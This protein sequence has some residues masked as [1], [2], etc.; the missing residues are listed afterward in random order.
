MKATGLCMVALKIS[1]TCGYSY[2]FEGTRYCTREVCIQ[3]EDN[4]GNM[5]LEA[6]NNEQ[7]TTIR[8]LRAEVERLNKRAENLEQTALKIAKQRDTA[9]AHAAT[10]VGALAPFADAFTEHNEGVPRCF[11]CGYDWWKDARAA[12]TKWREAQGQGG[13]EHGA[14]TEEPEGHCD[15]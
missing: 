11:K 4:M 13:D 3:R 6:T 9:Q 10:L 14:G 5:E 1:N 7:I 12:L 15:S 2:D 8:E